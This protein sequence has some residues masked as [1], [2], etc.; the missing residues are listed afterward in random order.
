[1]PAQD[2]ASPT[3]ATEHFSPLSPRLQND[4]Q[5]RRSL[6]SSLSNRKSL[7]GLGRRALGII[8][9]LVTVFLWTTSNFLASEIFAD[10]TYSKAFFVIYLNAAAF[11]L[12]LVPIAL[13]RAHDDGYTTLR[14]RV[15]SIR[16]RPG[17]WYKLLLLREGGQEGSSKP[18]AED[19][20]SSSRLLEDEARIGSPAPDDSRSGTKANKLDF[21]ETARL[22]FE[23]SILWFVSNYFV[24]ACLK[25]T[26]VASSTILASTS[27]IWTLLISTFLRTERFTLPKLF[28]VLSSLAGIVLISTVDLGSPDND[29]SRGSFP[30]KTASQIALGDAMALFSALCYGVYSVL[31]KRKIGDE[32]RVDMPLFFGL[33][34]LFNMLMLWP[35]FIVFHF[36]GIETFALPPTGRVWAIVLINAFLSLIADYA[37]AYS[38]LLTSPLVVTVGLG[39]TIPLSLIGQMVLEHQYSS[40]AYWLGA[41]IVLLSF[42]VVNRESSKVDNSPPRNRGS[43]EQESMGRDEEALQE[44]MT[45]GDLENSGPAPSEQHRRTDSETEPDANWNEEWT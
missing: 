29:D 23:F 6:S 44:T 26:T 21:R 2:P 17:N 8:L 19:P 37:W 36:T 1:M 4:R 43:V 9:L 16:R 7:G 14:T 40:I 15:Q 42:L 31:I 25:Y 33:V 12:A 27:S 5:R 13:K 41:L 34:G 24:G 11:A 18:D 45:G 38:M 32:S 10:D 30:H 39:L 20:E 22:G 28:G 35:L 3:S